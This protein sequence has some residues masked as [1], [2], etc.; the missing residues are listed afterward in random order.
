MAWTDVAMRRYA[1]AEQGMH[2]GTVDHPAPPVCD[3]DA[4]AIIGTAFMTSYQAAG[5][6]ELLAYGPRWW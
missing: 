6:A 2:G 3:P 4:N 5:T 1:E